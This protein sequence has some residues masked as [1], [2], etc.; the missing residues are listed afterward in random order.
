MSVAGS[1]GSGGEYGQSAPRGYSAFGAPPMPAPAA[2]KPPASGAPAQGELA[3]S[4]GS[5]HAQ[6]G[7]QSAAPGFQVT[8][9][10][11]FA[12]SKRLF[13]AGTVAC[14]AEIPA[15]CARRSGSG[16]VSV[17]GVAW[18]HPYSS[19]SMSPA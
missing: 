17:A 12:G 16:C 3:T 9:L 11:L 2:S 5:Y 13:C 14:A 8:A 7:Y 1:L 15:R 19:E 6:Q 4:Q 18:K 10:R